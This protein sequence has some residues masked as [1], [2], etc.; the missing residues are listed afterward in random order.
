MKHIRTSSVLAPLVAP[1]G[2]VAGGG[3]AMG[4]TACT[5]DDNVEQSAPAPRVQEETV[6]PQ[7][8]CE[9][10]IWMYLDCH[11][12][13]PIFDPVTRGWYYDHCLDIE[14]EMEWWC[15]YGS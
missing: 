13:P 9:G 4:T 6:K 10:L 7:S 1:V 15:T 11:N 8:N 12:G 14:A 2:L 5:T 3:L